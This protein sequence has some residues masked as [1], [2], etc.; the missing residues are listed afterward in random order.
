M[1]KSFLKP[2]LQKD[3][4]TQQLIDRHGI[5]DRTLN[6]IHHRYEGF[7]RNIDE[8]VPTERKDILTALTDH[9]FG[10]FAKLVE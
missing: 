2:Q 8:L 3:L 6:L 4:Y 9:Q 5:V 10:K 7:H 1:E